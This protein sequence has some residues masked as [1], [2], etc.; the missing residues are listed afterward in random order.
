MKRRTIREGINMSI[1]LFLVMTIIAFI[2]IKEKEAS[3]HKVE[4]ETKVEEVIEEPLFLYQS[5]EEGLIDALSYYDIVHPEIVY[6]QAVLETGN[7]KSDLC[8]IHNNLFG[9]YDSRKKRYLR[10]NHWTESVQA[11][12]NLIQCRYNS[13]TSYYRFLQRIHYAEDPYYISKLKKL[14]KEYEAKQNASP[15]SNQQ[16]GEGIKSPSQDSDRGGQEDLCPL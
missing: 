5:P 4:E 15:S 9:L 6:A 3:Q 1:A 13:P 2:Y 7:F 8:I 11:Y 14:E 10:F 12:K 16:T